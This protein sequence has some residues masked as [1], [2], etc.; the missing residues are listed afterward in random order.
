MKEYT[1]CILAK[2]SGKDEM[3]GQSDGDD[4]VNWVNNK[5]RTVLL[6]VVLNR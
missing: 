3:A 2:L 5:V 4:I 6:C 1:L